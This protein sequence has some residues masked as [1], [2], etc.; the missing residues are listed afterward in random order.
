MLLVSEVPG[1]FSLTAPGINQQGIPG[2]KSVD[3]NDETEV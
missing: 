3:N 1:D 2:I